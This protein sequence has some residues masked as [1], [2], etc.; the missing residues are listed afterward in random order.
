MS[1]VQAPAGIYES[2]RGDLIRLIIDFRT[3]YERLC[4]EAPTCLH[5]SGPTAEALTERGFKPGS[6]VAGMKIVPRL[7]D[8]V[9]EAVCSRD[10]KLFAPQP[11][12]AP[13]GS[14]KAKRIAAMA[15]K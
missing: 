1:I 12:A 11:A 8:A 2:K 15:A 14:S 13:P 9:D 3:A 5:V 4:G 6:L 7:G 10:E